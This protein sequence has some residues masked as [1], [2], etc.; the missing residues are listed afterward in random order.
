MQKGKKITYWIATLWLALGMVSTGIVQLMQMDEEV[1][2]FNELG[3]PAY[4]M[5]VL[6][7]WKM[8]G[9]IAILLPRFP[10]LKE[11]AY[12]GFFFAM[13]GA[14]LSHLILHNSFAEIAPSLLLLTLTFVS[15]YLR[16]DNRK[17]LHQ[18]T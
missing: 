15:W 9:T 14:A 11:W 12:A 16:P 17:I 2:K 13:S 6:G 10:M 7:I 1:Q 5:T 18:N 3:Y 8:L 4:L